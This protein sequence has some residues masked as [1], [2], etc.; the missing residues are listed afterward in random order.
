MPP[1]SHQVSKSVYTVSKSHGAAVE[2]ARLKEEE[3][4]KAKG[5][6]GEGVLT[7]AQRAQ[8][9]ADLAA[10]EEEVMGN[11]SKDPE[12]SKSTMIGRNLN[13]MIDVLKLRLNNIKQ[14]ASTRQE[15]CGHDV[16]ENTKLKSN[17]LPEKMG[18]DF[19]LDFATSTKGTGKGE[20]YKNSYSGGH[21]KDFSLVSADGVHVDPQ[22]LVLRT[23]NTT[24]ASKRVEQRLEDTFGV[25]TLGRDTK[26]RVKSKISKK[27]E[28][29]KL[30]R[31]RNLRQRL[32]KELTLT[33]D[34]YVTRS[35][36]DESVIFKAP[37]PGEDTFSWPIP[38]RWSEKDPRSSNPDNYDGE[39]RPDILLRFALE[40]IA[41][42][43]GHATFK[44]L[45]TRTA[46]QDYFVYLFW[47]LKVKF[48]Q[49]SLD[50]N[51]DEEEFLLQHASSQYVKIVDELSH[52]A[53]AEYEKDFL[54]RFFPYI[55]CHAM[56]FGFFYL[57]PGSRHLYTRSFRKT[58]LLQIVQILHGIQLCPTSVKVTWATLFPEEVQDEAEQ[59]VEDEVFP[60]AV[61]F[62]PEPHSHKDENDWD[63]EPP[64]ATLAATTD[65]A[66]LPS[67]SSKNRNK[68][69]H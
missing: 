23:R 42:P 54:F 40:R 50:G 10:L 60:T 17:D 2:A 4:K 25:A 31:K 59:E 58:L 52:R 6:T 57:C 51:G 13:Q 39:M 16:N 45:V 30:E 18:G 5:E 65:T 7:P 1:K 62:P 68:K 64:K 46:V 35:V 61:A 41:L 3:E 53:M 55:L 28:A 22:K 21:G 11:E 63:F 29:Q 47:L 15:Y 19:E 32:E 14:T 69:G 34:N 66:S 37:F 33:I 67:T 20:S 12:S 48:F 9:E 38:I 43:S 24:E 44:W 36:M 49:K 27:S 56:Y 26:Q 8:Q